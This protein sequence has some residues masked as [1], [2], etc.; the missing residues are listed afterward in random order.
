LGEECNSIGEALDLAGHGVNFLR[1]GV[2][3]VAKIGGYFNLL[4][5]TGNGGSGN[6]C[7]IFT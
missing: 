1:F 4:F 6:L 2:V 3:A 5:F 7:N